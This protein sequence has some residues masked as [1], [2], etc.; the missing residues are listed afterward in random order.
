MEKFWDTLFGII[1][2]VAIISSVT[3]LVSVI[4][5]WKNLAIFSLVV[6][7]ISSVIIIAK[8]SSIDSYESTIDYGRDMGTFF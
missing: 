3:L 8:A 2:V 4:F 5:T 6:L 7:F 1:F